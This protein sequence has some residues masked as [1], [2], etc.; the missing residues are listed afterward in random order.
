LSD[1][2]RKAIIQIARESL[3]RFQP[4]PEAAK[5][6]VAKPEVAK[7]EVAKPDKP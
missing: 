3:A 5:P 4:K 6:E 1:D 2:D 7:P